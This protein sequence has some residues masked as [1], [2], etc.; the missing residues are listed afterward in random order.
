MVGLTDMT[1]QISF[2]MH[3][4]EPSS[5]FIQQGP[6][7]VQLANAIGPILYD[8]IGQSD[9]AWWP[10]SAASGDEE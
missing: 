5:F 2:F 3:A 10:P 9:Q 7:F 4:S 1:T 6:D 8:T